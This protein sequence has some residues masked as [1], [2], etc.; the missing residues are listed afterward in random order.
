MIPS[1]SDSLEDLSGTRSSRH[2][3]RTDAIMKMARGVSRTGNRVIISRSHRGSMDDHTVFV[4]YRWAMSKRGVT[5]LPLVAVEI[6]PANGVIRKR[7]DIRILPPQLAIWAGVIVVISS[8]DIIVHREKDSATE[9]WISRVEVSDQALGKSR[10]SVAFRA[11]VVVR[12]G[13]NGGRNPRI[14]VVVVRENGAVVRVGS[15]VD[16][17][18]TVGY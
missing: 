16:F 13:H 1:G 12:G 8:L 9:V 15:T 11:M 5:I 17:R 2:G 10:I 18:K 14:R 4:F 3:N 7:V 6:I